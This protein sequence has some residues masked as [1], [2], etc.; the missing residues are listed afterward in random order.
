MTF[1][2]PFE[3]AIERGD[4]LL[5]EIDAQREL[6]ATTLDSIRKM[7]DGDLEKLSNATGFGMNLAKCNDLVGKANEQIG[8][9]RQLMGECAT[10]QAAARA[11]FADHVSFVTNGKPDV[12]P[13]SFHIAAKNGGV[14]AFEPAAKR[15]P[16]LIQSLGQIQLGRL[17]RE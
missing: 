2:T 14:A 8:K 10:A 17:F 6:V 16:D 11:S 9:L 4:D 5:G 7:F 3:K 12:G 15:Q 13:R 1:R